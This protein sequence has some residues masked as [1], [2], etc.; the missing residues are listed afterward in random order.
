MSGAGRP[1]FRH[2]LCVYD[3]VAGFTGAVAPYISEG[4]RAGDAVLVVVAAPKID[5][6]RAALGPEAGEVRFVDMGTVGRNPGVMIPFWRD[7]VDQHVLTGRPVRGVGEPVWPGRSRAAVAESH[8]NEALFNLAFRDDLDLEVLCPYDRSL[9]PEIMD[10]AFAR[11]PDPGDRPDAM[12]SYDEDAILD[13]VLTDP[14]PA[15]PAGARSLVFGIDDLRE[16]RALVR[17]E[18]LARGLGADR[19][20]DLVLAVTELAANSIRHGRGR[21]SLRVWHEDGHLVC[22][23]TDAG[24]IRD[25]LVG[26]RRPPTSP[27]NACGLWLVH[28]LCDLVQL[29]SSADGTVVRVHVATGA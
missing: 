17:A 18:G 26:R 15:P 9:A 2:E 22:E 16:L 10:R 29:R 19:C 6:L 14:L 21:G 5:L 8:H 25:P 13:A 27:P 23:V 1:G 20:D 4:V 28:H 24:R 7:F 3:G 12:S 11:H